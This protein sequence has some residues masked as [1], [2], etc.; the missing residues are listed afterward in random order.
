MKKNGFT[1]I[2]LLV[3]IAIIGIL[4]AMLLP[5]L[6]RAREAARR[7]SC[8]N[9]MKQ[10]GLM[11]KMYANESRAER[12]PPIHVEMSHPTRR[13]PDNPVTTGNINDALNYSFSPRIS[14]VFPEYL[15]DVK[16]SICPSDAEN[17]LSEKLDRSCVIY[18][19]SWDQFSNNPDIDE[20][21]WS[22]MD[23]SY[24]YLGWVF[25]KDGGDGDP[26][27][28]DTFLLETSLVAIGVFADFRT[29]E[30]AS[31]NQIWFPTQS[32]ATFTKA[33]SRSFTHQLDALTDIN[34]GF[35]EFLKP[36]DD[37]QQL[38]PLV[39]ENFDP[40]VDYGNGN[41]NTIFRLREG[42]ERFMITDLNNPGGSAMA[43]SDI[44][45]MWDQLSTY[46]QGFNHIPGGSNVL[47]MD[48]HVQFMRY[49]ERVPVKVSNAHFFG[50]MQQVVQELGLD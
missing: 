17:N 12:Y 9:N 29:P 45:I 14:A 30:D 18:D 6:S 33:H 38:D 31:N 32:I 46:P 15:T 23:D 43:Q 20:G 8:A 50:G 1:L 25:D 41:S 13:N 3:V 4:A 40:T 36:W 42:I 27:Q 44:H 35:T 5:A 34:K 10:Y 7:A 48:G 19:N 2:E 47:F 24:T 49:D 22:N 28:Y 11:F 39:V 26:T 21:C 16:I 37:D